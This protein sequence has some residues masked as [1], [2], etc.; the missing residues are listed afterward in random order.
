MSIQ[1][2][3]SYSDSLMSGLELQQGKRREMGMRRSRSLPFSLWMHSLLCSSGSN[4][5]VWIAREWWRDEEIFLRQ[6][7]RART[8]VNV[9]YV[10]LSCEGC[11]SHY[12]IA[13]SCG[14]FRNNKKNSESSSTRVHSFIVNLSPWQTFCQLLVPN[15]HEKG[16]RGADRVT[17]Q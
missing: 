17:R 3:S 11:D 2:E 12:S 16:N 10:L 1:K 5:V 4:T 8:L 7:F 15:W 6:P 9:R 13:F 14:A